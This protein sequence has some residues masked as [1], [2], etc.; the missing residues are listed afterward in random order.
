M[1]LKPITV[2]VTFACYA[3]GRQWRIAQGLP[4]D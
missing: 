2:A 1:R 3:I 4:A